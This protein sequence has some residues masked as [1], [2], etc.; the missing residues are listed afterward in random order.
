MDYWYYIIIA[1]AACFVLAFVL[2]LILRKRKAEE[3]PLII[4]AKE[5]MVMIKQRIHTLNSRIQKLDTDITSLM[6]AQ[7]KE[8][9]NLTA[10]EISL[11]NIPQKIDEYKEEIRVAIADIEDLK[12]YQSEIDQI[13]RNKKEFQEEK[14]ENLLD[15][16]KEKLRYRFN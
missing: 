2:Y 11:E 8:D 9:T 7:E 16:T 1:L 15:L 3:H 14:L 10:I 4:R 12:D 6:L 13:T 5:M